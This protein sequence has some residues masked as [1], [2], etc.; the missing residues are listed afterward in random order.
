MSRTVSPQSPSPEPAYERWAYSFHLPHSPRSVRVARLALRAVLDGHGMTELA[1]TAVLLTSEMVTNSYRYA[2]DGPTRVRV[3]GL[4]ES[5]LR[6]SVWDSNPVI[7]TPF[8][9]PPSSCAHG[10]VAARAAEAATEET[11]GRGLLLVQLCADDWGG[12]AYGQ[13]PSGTGSTGKFLWYELAH[14]C[15]PYGIA[16]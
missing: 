2:P 13:H 7:P 6:V 14:R 16:A 4:A 3:R 12:Y 9:Q 15:G 1:D 8:D 5:R 11:H 10:T